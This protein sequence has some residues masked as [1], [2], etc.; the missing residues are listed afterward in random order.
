MT[1]EELYTALQ[2]SAG[3]LTTQE[4]EH[5]LEEIGPNLLKPKKQVTRL[6]LF[7]NQFKSPIVLILLSAAIIL[8]FVRDWTDAVIILLIALGSAILSFI[9]E[10]NANSAVEKLQ[11]Q[12]AL[13]TLVL[14]D[15]QQQSI[16]SE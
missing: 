13:E 2:C 1:L 3:G 11:S 10:F 12:V 5:R 15:Q 6:N 8:A 4:A 16:L 9:Q 14:R 7:L